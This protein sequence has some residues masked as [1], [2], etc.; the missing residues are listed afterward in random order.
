M[1]LEMEMLLF[2]ENPVTSALNSSSHSDY[3]SMFIGFKIL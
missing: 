3:N 2:V 1:F